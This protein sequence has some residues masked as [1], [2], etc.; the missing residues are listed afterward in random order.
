MN[1]PHYFNKLHQFHQLN[2]FH[3]I[4]MLCRSMLA[5]LC[6]R[7]FKYSW[8]PSPHLLDAAQQSMVY[9][10]DDWMQH[11]AKMNYAETDPKLEYI[12]KFSTPV[13]W[14]ASTLIDDNESTSK[15]YWGDSIDFGL[16]YG[17]TIPVKSYLGGTGMLCASLPH[18]ESSRQDIL[19][20]LSVIEMLVHH[21]QINIE[22]L[23]IE[24]NNDIKSLTSREIE[25]IKWTAFGKTAEETGKILSISHTTVIFHL[26][27]ARKKLNASNKHQL[28]ARAVALGLIL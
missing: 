16:R 9:C 2:S 5:E 22:R 15:H 26:N 3:E 21:L 19:H 7:Y 13:V 8:Q 6:I 14:D 18:H 11:Y 10:P 1:T 28:T 17:V 25:I 12:K 20:N 23:L 4:S 24:Q 27:Q